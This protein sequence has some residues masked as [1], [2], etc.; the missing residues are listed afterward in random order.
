MSKVFLFLINFYQKAV[1]PLFGQ[2]CRYYPSCSQYAK[3]AIIRYGAIKGGW[4]AVKRIMRC[5]QF[6]PGGY[7]PVP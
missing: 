1:S 3:E 5:N 2:H 4:L 7:D 6:F